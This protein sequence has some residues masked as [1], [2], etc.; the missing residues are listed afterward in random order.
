MV[1]VIVIVDFIDCY[2]QLLL[3]VIVTYYWLSL[4]LVID[5]YLMVVVVDIVGVVDCFCPCHW[6]LILFIVTW[7]L[8]LLILFTNTWRLL[9]LILSLLLD[10]CCWSCHCYDAFVILFDCWCCSLFVVIDIDFVIVI[11]YWYCCCHCY[12]CY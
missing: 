10:G 11:D 3:I 9:L 7:W 2:S 12:C 8:L 5:C 1:V 6:L 4:L